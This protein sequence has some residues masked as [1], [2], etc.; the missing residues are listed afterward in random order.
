MS[1]QFTPMHLILLVEA[2]TG[3]P[4]SF[5]DTP[6]KHQYLKHLVQQGLVYSTGVS[7]AATAYGSRK[8]EQLLLT[9]QLPGN[10]E[11]GS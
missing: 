3:A 1:Q 2:Y 7:Y 4:S 9:M 8:I 5:P 11:L 6:T 10:G